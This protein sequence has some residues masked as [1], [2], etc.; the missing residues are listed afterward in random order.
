MVLPAE[1]EDLL[2]WMDAQGFITENEEYGLHG[3]LTA[4]WWPP[5]GTAVVFHVE[6]PEEAGL[7]YWTGWDVP[8]GVLV[9]FARTG[10]DGSRAAFWLDPDGRQRIVHLGSGSGSTLC[11]ELVRTP[12]DLLRLLAIGYDEICWLDADSAA[13]PP[14]R[15][16][17]TPA[18][19]E[20][21]REWLR[22]RGVS[23]PETAA[24]VVCGLE[25]M[26]D[27]PGSDDFRRWLDTNDPAR[28]Q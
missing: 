25:F 5:Y 14:E 12:L 26:D 27:P 22:A 15:E 1:F 19:N 13:A 8:D 28:S 20:P 7:E 11:C 24:E 6:T 21:Y 18:A 10:G 16:D 4:E 3:Q 23:I 17:G 9:P 2:D